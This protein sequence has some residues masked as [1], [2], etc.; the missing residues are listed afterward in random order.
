MTHPEGVISL[1]DVAHSGASQEYFEWLL[2]EV[3][4]RQR[5]L[6]V[7]EVLNDG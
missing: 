2:A 6:A 3:V 1:W 5:E 7:Q 4:E